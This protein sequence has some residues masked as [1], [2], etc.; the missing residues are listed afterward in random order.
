MGFWGFGVL[1]PRDACLRDYAHNKILTRLK[2]QSQRLKFKNSAIKVKN[3]PDPG[4]IL[5]HSFGEKYGHWKSIIIYIILLYAS[6]ICLIIMSIVE[7]YEM[8]L[9]T[10][11]KCVVTKSLP[12]Q[13]ENLDNLDKNNETN[14]ICFCGGI[15]EEEIE[16]RED[17]TDFCENYNTYFFLVWIIR[18]TAMGIISLIEK[19][20][21]D[22]LIGICLIIYSPE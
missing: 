2:N 14:V 9:P 13:N 6:I 22:S 5:W 12:E 19:I 16:S 18:L 3:A 20:V 4:E 17:Y 10:Y 11:T 1:G 7:Y 8:R 21:K 15:S